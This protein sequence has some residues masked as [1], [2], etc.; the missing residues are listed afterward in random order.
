M[1]K[2]EMQKWE[3]MNFVVH[4]WP[5]DGDPYVTYVNGEKVGDPGGM[6]R[7]PTHP[8]LLAYLNEMGNLGWEVASA[9]VMRPRQNNERATMFLLKRPK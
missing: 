3:Y 8:L 9:S 6:F 4:S 2:A 5:D 7:H 1:T